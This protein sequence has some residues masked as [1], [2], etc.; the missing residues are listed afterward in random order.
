M[1]SNTPSCNVKNVNGR[2]GGK[3]RGERRRFGKDEQ[4]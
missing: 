4:R 3:V 1:S 2:D